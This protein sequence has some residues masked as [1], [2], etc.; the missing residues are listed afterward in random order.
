MKETTIAAITPELDALAA[1]SMV[2]WKAPAVAIAVVH[3]GDT[4]LLKAYG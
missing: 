4:A 3:N 1:E 2:E